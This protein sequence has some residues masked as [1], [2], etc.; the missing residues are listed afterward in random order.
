ME[1]KKEIEPD[2]QGLID[3]GYS[4]DPSSIKKDGRS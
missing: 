4:F 3:N 2:I 1:L